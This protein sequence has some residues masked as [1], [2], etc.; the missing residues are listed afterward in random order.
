MTIRPETSIVA[1]FADKVQAALRIYGYPI[2]KIS[3]GSPIDLADRARDGRT[4][5][6][7]APRRRSTTHSAAACA[8]GPVGC[9]PYRL[10]GTTLPDLNRRGGHLLAASASA[11]PWYDVDPASWDRTDQPFG[12]QDIEGF[13]GGAFGDLVPLHDRLDAREGLARANLAGLDHPAQ[14]RGYLQVA[15]LI[16]EMI[17]SHPARL[18]NRGLPWPSGE[19]WAPR[20]PWDT[21]L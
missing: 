18:S 7:S 11:S 16:A 15:G 2:H 17:N 5:A 8:L 10:P 13:L 9:A 12:A 19:P 6:S 4:V 14:E 1:T 21:M 20:E 3:V